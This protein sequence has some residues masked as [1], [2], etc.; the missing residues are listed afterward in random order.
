MMDFL[1]RLAPPRE[2][3]STR[4]VAVRQSRFTSEN[5][6]PT[7]F[8]LS[9]WVQRSGDDEASLSVTD[10][11]AEQPRPITD[12]QQSHTAGRPRDSG[13]MQH[14]VANGTASIQVPDQAHN[15]A[16]TDPSSARGQRGQYWQRATLPRLAS[17]SDTAALAASPGPQKFATLAAQPGTASPLSQALL[18]QRALASNDDGQVVHVTIGRID[19]VANTAPAPTPRRTAVPRQPTVTLADYLRTGNGNRQ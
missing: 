2:T 14:P 3:D 18:A 5:P 7:M 15:H 13:P 17:P 8:G 11:S 10:A 9:R 16:V 19:V 6:M 12:V 4:A 1:R